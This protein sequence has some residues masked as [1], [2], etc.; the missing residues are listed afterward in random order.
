ML[1]STAP[2]NLMRP[3]VVYLRVALPT[4]SVATTTLRGAC[5]CVCVLLSLSLFVHVHVWCDGLPLPVFDV[6]KHQNLSV[7]DLLMLCLCFLLTL[8][9]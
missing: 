1:C 2:S 6:L 8:L 4:A 7:F 9:L 5:V 3:R